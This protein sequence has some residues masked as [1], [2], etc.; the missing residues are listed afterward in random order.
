MSNAVKSAFF[1]NLRLLPP[2][3]LQPLDLP[4]TTVPHF[5]ELILICLEPEAHGCGI[6]SNVYTMIKHSRVYRRIKL[7]NDKILSVNEAILLHSGAYLKILF[8]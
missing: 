8:G 1:F 4:E 6:T 2:V 7:S 5:K 3:F